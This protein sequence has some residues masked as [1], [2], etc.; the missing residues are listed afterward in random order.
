MADAA[1]RTACDIAQHV[2]EATGRAL[3]QRDFDR[4]RPFFLLPQTVTTAGKRVE[5]A[6]S[7]DLK[8]AFFNMCDHFETIG[9]TEL[10]RTC[11]AAEFRGPD[12]IAS[13]HESIVRCGENVALPP[14]PVYSVMK[15]VGDAWLVAGSD[16]ML[17][18]DH[19]Q[20]RAL[21]TA[22]QADQ[23]AMAIYQEHLDALSQALL[24]GDFEAFSARISLPHRITTQTDLIE[25]TTL[26]QLR[27][28]FRNFSNGYRDSG[29]TDFFR[30]AEMAR[31]EAVDEIIGRHISHRLCGDARLVA[32]YPNR[33]R[34]L[35]GPDG[36]WRETHCAN[37]VLNTSENFHHWTRVADQ[38]V[39]PEL[40]MRPQGT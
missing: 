8:A 12:E 28:V 19:P 4:F 5:L 10:R 16:Y 9:V 13:T 32:P 36:K 1:T 34:L 31:F 25:I 21:L 17:D 2:L 35:Q 22:E 29:M 30:I 18:D 20:A 40:D 33:V 7:D 37:A 11:I 6:T 23:T 26:Q 15:R 39:L 38:P 27:D 24:E 3:M 14:Y